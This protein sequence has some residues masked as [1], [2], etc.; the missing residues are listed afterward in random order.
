VILNKIRSAAREHTRKTGKA[1]TRLYVSVADYADLRRAVEALT[2]APYGVIEGSPDMC[3][4][5]VVYQVVGEHQL[6]V[7]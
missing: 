1:P 7:M 6:A 3:D 5:M 2:H 4:G